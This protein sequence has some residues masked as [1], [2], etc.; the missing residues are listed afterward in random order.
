MID[1]CR[2]VVELAGGFRIFPLVRFFYAYELSVDIALSP[3][4]SIAE[5]DVL[6]SSAKIARE[7]K[8]IR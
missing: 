1:D 6:F 4:S 5:I 3:I 8:T 7:K 2:A